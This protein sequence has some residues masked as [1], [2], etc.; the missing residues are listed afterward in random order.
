V[1]YAR[2]LH[3]VLDWPVE[4]EVVADRQ[5]TEFRGKIGAGLP[6][7]RLHCENLEP[8]LDRVEPAGRSTH[9]EGA[10]TTPDFV[11]IALSRPRD[12]VELTLRSASAS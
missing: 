11:E 5:K 10:D 3:A 1:D 2:D 6:G 9:I 7:L 4:Y 12:A 8:S